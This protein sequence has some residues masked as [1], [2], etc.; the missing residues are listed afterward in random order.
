MFG[1]DTATA[2]LHPT[3]VTP[4]RHPNTRN[5]VHNCWID[6]TDLYC[7]SHGTRK[8]EVLD[9]STLTN[10]IYLSTL[11]QGISGVGAHDVTV[12]DKRAY[13]SL[14][15]G[16]FA[17]YDM[18][19]PGSPVLLGQKTYP[20]AANH[21]AWPT[22]DRK[23][24]YTTDENDPGGVGGA[25]RIWDISKLPTITQVGTYKAPGPSSSIVHNVHVVGDYLL[26]TYYKE[27]IRIASIKNDP[28][29]PVEIAHYDTFAPTGGGCF[30]SSKYAGCWGVYPF[31][32]QKMFVSDLDSGA[33]ILDLD[34]VSQ[35]FTAKSQTVPIGSTIDLNFSFTSKITTTDINAFGVAII[36]SVNG[37]PAFFP[38]LIDGRNLAVGQSSPNHTIT[39]PVP[40]GLPAMAVGFT[41]Y[42][43]LLDPVQF[44][45]ESDILIQLK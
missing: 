16:G 21:N 41:A 12:L 42:S 44:T 9:I 32:H 11:G 31:N 28:T 33:Y 3:V 29:N 2:V 7:V 14:W 30:W 43:G 20:S 38:V 24:L 27:G 39:I 17:I 25:V 4:I 6:G 34:F 5:G 45:A 40:P 35:Q 19:T 13:C 1:H 23:Y 22:D 15:A 10:P 26:T 36:S 37:A 8:I 18:T